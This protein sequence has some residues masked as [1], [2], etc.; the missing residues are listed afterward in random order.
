MPVLWPKTSSKQGNSQLRCV[1]RTQLTSPPDTSTRMVERRT[2]GGIQPAKRESG[3]WRN[4]RDYGPLLLAIQSDE[5]V[6]Q[7][8]QFWEISGRLRDRDRVSPDY[9]IGFL[10]SDA[11]RHR[12]LRDSSRRIPNWR[13]HRSY[14]DF[15]FHEAVQDH[16]PGP[17]R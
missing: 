7:D 10:V 6:E 15:A 14:R 3:R 17:R 13:G 2:Q 16:D 4:S 8:I 1:T 11:G 12:G 5:I 9:S